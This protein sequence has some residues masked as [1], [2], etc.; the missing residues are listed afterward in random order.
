MIMDFV[1]VMERTGTYTDLSGLTSLCQ[2]LQSEPESPHIM[3]N[4]T[5]TTDSEL[6]LL[7]ELIIFTGI[8][9]L[10]HSSTIGNSDFCQ[11][12]I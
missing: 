6:M 1:N 7:Q 12:S 11:S 4:A 2:K 8:T 10:F 3:K 9:E 5:Q